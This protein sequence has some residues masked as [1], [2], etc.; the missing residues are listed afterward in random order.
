MNT[1]ALSSCTL[2]TLGLVAAACGGRDAPIGAEL[3][4]PEAREAR[5]ALMPALDVG[6]VVDASITDRI[7][8]D[9]ILVNVADARLLGADPRI[10]VGGLKLIASEHQLSSVER[11]ELPFPEGLLADEDLAVY[12]RLAATPMLQGASVVVRA[13]LYATAVDADAAS[14]T[15]EG[16]DDGSPDPDGDPAMEDPS[17]PDPDGDPAMGDPG[18]PD[19][20]G[21]PALPKRRRCSP[22]PDGDPARPCPRELRTLRRALVGAG[23]SL[24]F[25]LRGFD[26]VDLVVGFND[27]AKLDVVLSV[28]AARWFTRDAVAQLE[29]ALDDGG[30]VLDEQGTADTE[31]ENKTVVISGDPQ[32]MGEDNVREDGQRGED[33]YRLLQEGSTDPSSMRSR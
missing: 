29:Q 15:A 24:P 31:S 1:R 3:R 25:E 33:D 17:S 7:V 2:F 26:E 21:D 5:I 18:S 4:I 32:E 27:N 14:L 12:L 6:G 19:P 30:E 28:P 20:D 23:D 13:R 10:P 9:E 22:D 11:T 16:G 8:I